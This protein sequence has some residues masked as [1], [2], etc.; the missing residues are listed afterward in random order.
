MLNESN[1]E[2]KKEKN[3]H[4][5]NAFHQIHINYLRYKKKKQKERRKK[6]SPETNVKVNI[7]ASTKLMIVLDFCS[8][9]NN[10]TS[11]NRTLSTFGYHCI[12]YNSIF[13][14]WKFKRNRFFINSFCVLFIQFQYRGSRPE[15][16]R[17]SKIKQ[18]YI[19]LMHIR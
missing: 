16:Q 6:N 10:R 19:I 2:Q 9:H 18:K 5:L 13:F 1:R 15:A 12:H 11:L 3:T 7:V 14:S 17:N 4:N 8:G